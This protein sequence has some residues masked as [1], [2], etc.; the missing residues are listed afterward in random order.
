MTE[1][2]IEPQ[3]IEP[4]QVP[5]GEKFIPIKI[6]NRADQ[7]NEK[8]DVASLSVNWARRDKRDLADIRKKIIKYER[9]S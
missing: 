1:K 9:E 2:I 6:F 4:L 8:K 3:T 7:A 5:T